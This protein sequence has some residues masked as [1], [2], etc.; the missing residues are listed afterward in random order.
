MPEFKEL[1]Y[2]NCLLQKDIYGE[3]KDELIELVDSRVEK[4]LRKQELLI[5]HD[6]NYSDGKNLLLDSYD[7]DDGCP[8]Y[9]DL[10]KLMADKNCNHDDGIKEYNVYIYEVR[11]AKASYVKQLILDEL[12]KINVSLDNVKMNFQ[13]V[14]EN[15]KSILSWHTR[16]E[17]LR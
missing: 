5:K 4:E 7:D 8:D 6:Y 16:I 3:L 13:I 14:E 9:A 15:S 1:I 12:S 10:D 17:Y 2:T 11:K